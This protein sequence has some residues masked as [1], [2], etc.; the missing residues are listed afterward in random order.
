MRDGKR[1]EGRWGEI[2]PDAVT[3]V[4]KRDRFTVSRA[5]IVSVRARRQRVRGRVIGTIGGF[6]A[7]MAAALQ[8]PTPGAARVV[9]PVVLA[10][11]YGLGRLWDHD[12]REYVLQ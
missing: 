7:G 4:G 10:A 8:S 2:T 12:S 11:G 6:Y 3:L 5:S 9:G 1:V